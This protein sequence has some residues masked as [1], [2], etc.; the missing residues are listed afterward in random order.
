MHS[1]KS[2]LI[3][4][5]NRVL[6]EAKKV[7][8]LESDN[9]IFVPVHAGGDSLGWYLQRRGPGGGHYATIENLS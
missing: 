1:E 2:R 7:E 4:E 5:K 3:A 9:Q 8:E 6:N